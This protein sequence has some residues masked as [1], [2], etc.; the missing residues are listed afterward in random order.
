MVLETTYL[1]RLFPLYT[2]ITV[3]FSFNSLLFCDKDKG[4]AAVYLTPN[5]MKGQVN[6]SGHCQTVSKQ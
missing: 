4:R 6:F 5:P 1:L 2:L 3:K